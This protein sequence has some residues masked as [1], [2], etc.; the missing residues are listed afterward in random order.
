[1]MSHW[2]QKVTR[3]GRDGYNLVRAVIQHREKHFKPLLLEHARNSNSVATSLLQ[4]DKEV[5]LVKY[6]GLSGYIKQ[7]FQS[8]SAVTVADSSEEN[9][10]TANSS[11]TAK[12]ARIAFMVTATMKAE[13]MDRLGYDVD[14]IKSM[15]PLQASLILNQSIQPEEL[16]TKL[17]L[18][19]Q[20]Y[21][22]QRQRE[23][24]EMRLLQAEQEVQ[25]VISSVNYKSDEMTG[26]TQ[27]FGGGYMSRNEL[28]E[29]RK[30]GSFFSA[31]EWFEVIE[32][33][34]N[35]E[36]SRVGLYQDKE[37]AELGLKTR[38]DIAEA[39]KTNITFDIHRIDWKDLEH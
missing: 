29:N 8:T 5:G 15:T 21:E 37:E 20:E 24:Q 6:H 26:K 28:N 39:K 9:S 11:G 16:E 27:Y 30:I 36:E 1:M 2:A 32:I 35:G 14:Q 17:P 10:L 13:L 33:N 7:R 3:V 34:K 19:E 23:E 18:A 38:R 25:Q 4:V 22:A 31:S 12:T